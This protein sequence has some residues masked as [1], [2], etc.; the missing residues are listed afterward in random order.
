MSL[1]VPERWLVALRRILR[2]LLSGGLNTVF[3]WGVYAMLLQVLPYHVSYTVAFG[4]GVVFA[5]FLSRYYVF[6]RSGGRN[7]L[8]WIFCIY[9]MQYLLGLTLVGI[10][11]RFLHAPAVW[12]PLAATVLSL[13]VVYSLSSLIFHER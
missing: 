13:P 7:G 3:T 6:R 9:L 8:V 11:V 1:P 5:Y 12:A 10:W 4:L 2:F